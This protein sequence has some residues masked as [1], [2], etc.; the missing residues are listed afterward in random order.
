[1]KLNSSIAPTKVTLIHALLTALL[2][3][4]HGFVFAEV[5][6][7]DFPNEDIRGNY[8]QLIDELRCLVCQNQN[9]AASDADLANDLR[10]ETY[11]MLL[12]GKTVADVKEFMV[13]RYGEFVLYKP[14]FSPATWLIWIGPF[15]LLA[16]GLTIAISIA[17]KSSNTGARKFSQTDAKRIDQLLG[18]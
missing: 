14:P 12:N 4:F 6:L 9:L 7:R 5:E 18:K 1:M 3:T 2:I 16:V 15:V 13:A 10:D 17:R 8:L 11:E